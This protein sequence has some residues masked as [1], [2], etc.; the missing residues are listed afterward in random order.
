MHDTASVGFNTDQPQP[1]NILSTTDRAQTAGRRMSPGL[2]IETSV[3]DD[4]P[5]LT[6]QFHTPSVPKRSIHTEIPV[7][8]TLL[9]SSTMLSEGSLEGLMHQIPHPIVPPRRK[10]RMSQ[11]LELVAASHE[12][13]QEELT[14]S[15]LY[16]PREEDNTLTETPRSYVIPHRKAIEIRGTQ[17]TE[18]IT[19]EYEEFATSTNLQNLLQDSINNEQEQ[20]V[21]FAPVRPA[22]R[23]DTKKAQ[24]LERTA[25]DPDPRHF[26]T[27]DLGDSTT[28]LESTADD[29]K[30]KGVTSWV[31]FKDGKRQVNRSSEFE[32][33]TLGNVMSYTK[34]PTRTSSTKYKVVN[35]SGGKKDVQFVDNL[36]TMEYSDDF[37][38]MPTSW[39]TKLSVSPRQVS[40]Q[41]DLKDGRKQTFIS[42][43]KQYM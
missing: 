36:N 28:F 11:S 6:E 3:K 17:R 4:N 26:N 20:P 40:K 37:E 23:I 1:S 7:K 2:V 19:Q 38:S 27:F 25:V 30:Q 13:L 35:V 16:T 41:I 10:A 33:F 15:S 31:E 14:L 12:D 32:H 43:S 21:V 18:L 42:S 34:E 39:A 22:R 5:P 29:L 24:A 9:K 8:G